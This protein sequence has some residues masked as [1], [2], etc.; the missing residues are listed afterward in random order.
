MVFFCLVRYYLSDEAEW[1]VKELEIEVERDEN[2]G[3][4]LQELRR[5]TKLAS[6]W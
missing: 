5:I 4:S 1:L 6:Q 2:G 3:V